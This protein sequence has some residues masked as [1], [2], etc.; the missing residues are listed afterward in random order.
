MGCFSFICPQ[1]GDPINSDSFSGE[2]CVLMLLQDGKVIDEMS[3]QYN[4]YGCVFKG[5]S[6]ERSHKWGLDWDDVCELLFSDARGTGMA[7]YHSPCWQSER[8]MGYEPR[9][10]DR[11][12]EQGWGEYKYPVEV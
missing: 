12:P 3:G 11:D 5:P 1:C 8:R 7:A 9:V 4:S 6:C 10:S 2:H